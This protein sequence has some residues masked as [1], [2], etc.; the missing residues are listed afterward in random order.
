MNIKI[1]KKPSFKILVKEGNIGGDIEVR[2]YPPVKRT[3]KIVGRT[4]FL[5]FPYVIFGKYSGRNENGHKGSW[6]H[7]AFA[8]RKLRSLAKMIYFPP[9][10]N[11]VREEWVVCLDVDDGHYLQSYDSTFED[12]IHKFWNHTFSD[13]YLSRPFG[14]RYHTW[15][16]MSLDEVLKAVSETLIKKSL[17]SFIQIVEKGEGSD[18]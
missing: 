2:I 7:V 18:Y 5:Q 12:L 8:N 15:Q 13:S 14:D 4:Y 11:I 16:K 3:V 17:S 1:N 10:G 6:L 9:F